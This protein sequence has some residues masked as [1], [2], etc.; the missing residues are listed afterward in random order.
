MII[1]AV[2]ITAERVLPG[3]ERVAQIIGI[4]AVTTGLLMIARA[5]GI[6]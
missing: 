6:T 4:V 3:G 2:A 5:A 1:V